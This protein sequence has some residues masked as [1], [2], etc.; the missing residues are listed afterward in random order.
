MVP[1]QSCAAA[2]GCNAGNRNHSNVW[3][4]ATASL[5]VVE[6]GWPCHLV[7]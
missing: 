6:W 4:Q 1:G 7:Y 3:K 2:M 5:S